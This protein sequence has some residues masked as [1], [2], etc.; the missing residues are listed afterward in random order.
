MTRLA[1]T[2]VL[3]ASL[4]LPSRI[5]LGQTQTDAPA[6]PGIE[7]PAEPPTALDLAHLDYTLDGIDLF[8]SSAFY[9]P[10]TPFGASAYH[11]ID[12]HD[13]ARLFGAFSWEISQSTDLESFRQRLEQR[14]TAVEWLAR[15]HEK[16]IISIN[17]MPSWLSRS[18]SQ[19]P[20]EGF[21]EERNTHG[22]RDWDAWSAVVGALVQLLRAVRW[23]AD[24]LRDL[25][26]TGHPLLAGGHR[27]LFEALREDGRRR[28]GPPIPGRRWA[29]PPSVRGGDASSTAPIATPS[30]SS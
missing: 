6:A 20:V 25:E 4:L 3:A 2:L 21:Y 9:N 22:P 10:R 30:P 24:V 27:R 16:L 12:D 17:Y 29:A 14:R 5:G 8:R 19:H 28:S 13:A 18:A 1:L 7:G 26:R 11:A 15:T 23:R